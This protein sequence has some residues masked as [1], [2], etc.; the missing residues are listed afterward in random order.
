MRS[1]SR[2][3]GCS[4]NTVD[5]LMLDTGSVAAWYHYE[6]VRG[7]SCRAIECDEI[8]SFCYSKAVNVPDARAAP[9]EA[10]SVW[11]W[12]AV[13]ADSKLFVS[14]LAGGRDLESGHEFIRD[15][16]SRVEGRTQITTDGYS[17][18][19][20][21]IELHFGGDVDYGMLQKRVSSM[22]NLPTEERRYSPQRTPPAHRKLKIIGRPLEEYIS[23]SLVERHNLTMRMSMRRYTRLTNAFSK[24]IKQHTASLALYSLYY[25]FCRTHLSLKNPYPR[26]PAMAAGIADRIYD[27]DWIVDLIDEAAPKPRRP[28]KYRK[29]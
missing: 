14:W 16:R 25:N 1:I 11:T 17:V 9:P 19:R 10:G 7:L 5:K 4:I 12:T 22:D 23:T 15:L 8:W 21:A 27:L 20:E 28:K 18:Y 24:R 13:D 26:T 3:V 29:R 6:H 2:V